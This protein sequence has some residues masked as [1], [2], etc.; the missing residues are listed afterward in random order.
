M[1]KFKVG[2]RV[3]GTSLDPIGRAYAGVIVTNYGDYSYYVM[4]KVGEDEFDVYVDL[5]LGDTMEHATK[6]HKLLAGDENV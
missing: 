4:Q 3:V 1:K 6:L 5:E 2:D